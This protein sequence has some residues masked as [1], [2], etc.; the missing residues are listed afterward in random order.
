MTNHPLNLPKYFINKTKHSLISKECFVAFT[1]G[2]YVTNCLSKFKMNCSQARSA[3]QLG[4]FKARR[5]WVVVSP[6]GKPVMKNLI[7]L[8]RLF[9]RVKCL[10]K[11]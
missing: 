3:K 10:L 8:N 2:D 7:I 11:K 4:H 9:W 6:T 5:A 1:F